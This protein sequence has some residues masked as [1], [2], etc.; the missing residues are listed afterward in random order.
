MT[1]RNIVVP[2]ERFSSKQQAEGDSLR[3]QSDAIKGFIDKNGYILDDLGFVD[4]GLSGYT[5]KNI[6]GGALGE[7][8]QMLKDGTFPAP[9]K[10]ILLVEKFDRLSRLP[11]TDA[12][13]DIIKPILR[14]GLAIATVKE[15]K[16]LTNDNIDDMG[17]FLPIILLLNEAN[18][19]V[20]TLTY[21]V[22][23]AYDDKF[24]R[25]VNE[26]TIMGHGL[27][28]WLKYNQ[29]K[30]EIL[31]IPNKVKL[32]QTMFSLAAVGYS[33]NKIANY[34]KEHHEDEFLTEKQTSWN[35]QS[36]LRYMKNRSVTGRYTSKTKNRPT[37]IRENYFPVV[38]STQDFEK[39]QAII[40]SRTQ[41]KI[42]KGLKTTGKDGKTKNLFTGLLKCSE[43]GMGLGF[44][45]SGDGRGTKS[46]YSLACNGR[47]NKTGCKHAT[48]QYMMFERAIMEHIRQINLHAVLNNKSSVNMIDTYRSEL[49]LKKQ[50]H[51]MIMKQLQGALDEDDMLDFM[52]LKRTYKKQMKEIE[53]KIQEEMIKCVAVPNFEN[54]ELD[55]FLMDCELDGNTPDWN[56]RQKV[57]AN[58]RMIIK[59]IV[60]DDEKIKGVPRM[61]QIHFKNGAVEMVTTSR[62]KSGSI[63]IEDKNKTEL[64]NDQSKSDYDYLHML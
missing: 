23:K 12:I 25:L 18:A 2:Y 3:R 40:N 61:H 11:T 58:L 52:I 49:A 39:V 16:I 17:V 31:P 26:G 51:D 33:S 14:T 62:N 54:V 4:K 57:Q 56:Q 37:V 32:L 42:N 28:A 27:P 22:T 35:V 59:K 6:K 43:C 38:I 41:S 48:I 10:R 53:Q 46:K 50:Q 63:Y 5:G 30:T 9:H 29:D 60:V 1:E 55:S 24:E 45:S 44:R 7:I 36:V 8:L 13:T 20:E 19:Y 21:H 47:L 34:L 15:G 64:S